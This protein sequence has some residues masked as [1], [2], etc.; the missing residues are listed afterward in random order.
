[1]AP[2]VRFFRKAHALRS[3]QGVNGVVTFTEVGHVGGLPYLATEYTEAGTLREFLERNRPSPVALIELVRGAAAVV[4]QAHN[5]G[6]VHGDLSP[7][8]VL[9]RADGQV[10]LKGF[11]LAPEDGP[12]HPEAAP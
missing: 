1:I 2:L 4:A 12:P 6:V 11:G 10:L 3:L 5:R 9:V 8:S 7:G